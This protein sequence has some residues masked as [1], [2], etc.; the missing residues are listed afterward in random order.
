MNLWG[1]YLCAPDRLGETLS[2]LVICFTPSSLASASGSLRFAHIPKP[3]IRNKGVE[4]LQTSPSLQWDSSQEKPVLQSVCFGVPV[5]S[6][7]LELGRKRKAVLSL[8]RVSSLMLWSSAQSFQGRD[9]FFHV[10]YPS[11][12]CRVNQDSIHQGVG[13]PSLYLLLWFHY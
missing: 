8:A 1:I 9:P 7:Q 13:H 11:N 6:E 4:I 12:N 2:E 10:E 3:V 5:E